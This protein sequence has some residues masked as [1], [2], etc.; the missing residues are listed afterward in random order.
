MSKIKK[1][2]SRKRI[3]MVVKNFQKNVL[4]GSRLLLGS[5]KGRKSRIT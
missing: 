4:N 2:Y 3:A 5:F 1:G